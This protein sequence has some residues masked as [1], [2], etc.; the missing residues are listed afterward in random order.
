MSIELLGCLEAGKQGGYGL[1][2]VGS[3]SDFIAF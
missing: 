3:T 1:E 2:E